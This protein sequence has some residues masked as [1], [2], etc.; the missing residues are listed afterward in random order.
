MYL[1][2]VLRIMDG[3]SETLHTECTVLLLVCNKDVQGSQLPTITKLL[4]GSIAPAFTD[5]GL[6]RA[7]L[8]EKDIR[9]VEI[10]RATNRAV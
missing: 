3:F 9:G 10:K 2:D 4:S 5:G 6:S 7:V 1:H 8:H